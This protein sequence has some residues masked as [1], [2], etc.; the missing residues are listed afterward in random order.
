ML[1]LSGHVVGDVSEKI[2]VFQAECSLLET[3]FPKPLQDGP[4]SQENVCNS[5]SHNPRQIVRDSPDWNHNT[6]FHSQGA[7]LFVISL[8]VVASGFM[9]GL[10]PSLGRE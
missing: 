10:W 4:A 6:C 7:G 9:V 3:M 2:L 1:R 8:H 5:S